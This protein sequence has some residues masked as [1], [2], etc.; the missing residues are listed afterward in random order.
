MSDEKILKFRNV[1]SEEIKSL[2]S[3]IEVLKNKASNTEKIDGPF[4]YESILTKHTL[5]VF[6]TRRSEL[7]QL[8]H[9]YTD[10]ME[11]D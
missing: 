7:V 8:L 9:K 4:S 10:I 2:D 1:L 11:I 3:D 5:E 6:T